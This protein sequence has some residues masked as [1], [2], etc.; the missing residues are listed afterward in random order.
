MDMN[1]QRLT[2]EQKRKGLMDRLHKIG[3]FVIGSVV[4]VERICGKTNCACRK[5]G[6][7]HPAMFVTWK[8]DG[9]TVTLYVPR[10]LEKEVEEWVENYKKAK[11]LLGQ[12][13]DAQKNIIRLR[14]E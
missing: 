11:E 7:K 13:S 5:G 9:K 6:P 8:Q 4:H 14:E 1:D 2:L 12:I 10:K 3:P